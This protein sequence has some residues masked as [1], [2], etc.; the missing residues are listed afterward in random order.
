METVEKQLLV[1]SHSS[2]TTKLH[3]PRLIEEK[4]SFYVF[5]MFQEAVFCEPATTAADLQMT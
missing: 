3:G 5:Q 4:C 2:V 1:I